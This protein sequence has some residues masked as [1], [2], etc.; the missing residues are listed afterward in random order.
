MIPLQERNSLLNAL[1]PAEPESG[2]IVTMPDGQIAGAAHAL[3]LYKGDT[4]I[5]T[6]SSFAVIPNVSRRSSLTRAIT[7]VPIKKDDLIR[8]RYV[9]YNFSSVIFIEYFGWIGHEQVEYQ[10]THDRVYKVLHVLPLGPRTI[11]S[12]LYERVCLEAQEQEKERK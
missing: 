3:H 2:E 5:G 4:L 6:A 9:Q 12:N 10:T 8:I 1:L 7:S 11:K